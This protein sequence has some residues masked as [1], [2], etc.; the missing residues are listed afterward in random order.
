MKRHWIH[1]LLAVV[2]SFALAGCGGG[3]SNQTVGG[4]GGGGGGGGNPIAVPLFGMLTDWSQSQPLDSYGSARLWDN[5]LRWDVF[6][7]G[8]CIP[9]QPFSGGTCSA[10]NNDWDWTRLDTSLANVHSWCPNCDVL[11]TF[12]GVADYANHC[13]DDGS[14]NNGICTHVLLQDSCNQGVFACWMPSDLNADGSGANQYFKDYFTFLATH[15]NGLDSTHASVSYMELPWNELD[16]DPCIDFAYNPTACAN[17]VAFGNY[18]VYATYSQLQRIY[19]DAKA[20]IAPLMPTVKF[21]AGNVA[22]ISARVQVLRNL[23]YC[24]DTPVSSCTSPLS[25][26]KGGPGMDAISW[27]EYLRD[28][29]GQG[30]QLLGKIDAVKDAVEGS[31]KSLPLWMTEGGWGALA[32]LPDFEMEAGFVARYMVSCWSGA[33]NPDNRCYWYRYDGGCGKSNG[34]NYGSLYGPTGAGCTGADGLWWSGKAYN[35]IYSWVAGA[36]LTTPCSA[37]NDVWTCDLSSSSG[38][39]EQIVWWAEQGTNRA[40]WCSGDTDPVTHGTCDSLSYNYPSNYT[41]FQTL[42]PARG[43]QGLSGGTVRIT[44]QPILLTQ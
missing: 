1:T 36:T 39:P 41:H 42:D 14:N 17:G 20:T 9:G 22:E 33:T 32:D 11:F 28:G 10:D 27:H 31:D 24:D 34:N 15:L 2:A 16:R 7:N 29:T 37:S 26:T 43:V 38:A 23:L 40:S 35:Q 3:S 5:Q 19:S 44:G 30:E 21:V 25:A 8:H 4:G 13:N 6:A 12:G 18:S